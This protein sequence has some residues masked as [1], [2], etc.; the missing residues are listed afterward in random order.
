MWTTDACGA[1]TGAAEPARIDPAAPSDRMIGMIARLMRTIPPGHRYRSAACSV[2]HEL[3]GASQSYVSYCQ[4]FAFT[5]QN[6]PLP[7]PLSNTK[8]FLFLGLKNSSFYAV[9]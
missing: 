2:P 8:S 9:T 7:T 4:C 6:K 5:D 3:A 1:T